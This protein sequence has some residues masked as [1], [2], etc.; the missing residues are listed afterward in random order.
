MLSVFFTPEACFSKMVEKLKVSAPCWLNR[1]ESTVGED[2][3][4]LNRELVQAWLEHIGTGD[5]G[6][7]LKLASGIELTH[8]RVVNGSLTTKFGKVR[9]RRIGYSLPEHEYVFPMDAVLNLPKSSYSYE[10]QR[11]VARRASMSSFD[12][13][14]ELT[15][16]VSG[17]KIGKRQAIEIVEGCIRDFDAFYEMRKARKREKSPVLVLTTDGKGI[18]MRDDGLRAV[19][20]AKAE[21]STTK[22]RTRLARGEKANRKRIAQVASIYTIERFCR[23]PEEVVDELARRQAYQR[24]PRPSAKRVWASVEKDAAHVIV[25]LFAEAHKRDPKRRKEWV[26]LVDGQRHQMLLIRSILKKEQ[27][28]ATVILDII[29]VIE[30]LWLAARIFHEETSNECERWVEDKL[31][32]ILDGRAGRVA[33][34]I[35]MSAAKTKLTKEQRKVAETS[36]RYIAQRK[37]YMNYRNYLKLGYPIATGVIE[38]ACR[39]LIKDRMDITGARWSLS[40][41]EAVL[42][43]RSLVTSDDFDDYWKFHLQREHQRNHLS[44]LADPRQLATLLPS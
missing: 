5:I 11:F 3:R 29:H 26:V 35:R 27:V 37:R 17:V 33:G 20:K 43:L 36:A 31:K 34:S 41:A 39:H 16:E 44:K 9:L 32:G 15:E 4:E 42:K 40:G 10:L 14:L 23:T 19:T 2:S 12:E 25:E 22:M 13:V 21:K 6:A 18:V 1:I 38:G 8:R 7:R 28:K 24:R 30:Y